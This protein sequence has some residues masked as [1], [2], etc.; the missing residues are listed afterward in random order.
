MILAA[1]SAMASAKTSRGCTRLAVS[2][3]IVTTRLVIKRL[4]PSSVRQTKY[5]CFL[6]RMSASSSTAFSGLSMIGWSLSSKYRRASSKLARITGIF[7][8]PR[9]TT[10]RKSSYETSPPFWRKI[11]STSRAILPTSARALPLPITAINSSK[12][13]SRAAP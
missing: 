7:A 11:F 12:S 1:R 6:S 3:P 8:S 9:P 10:L 4:A 5:S 2:V 13:L